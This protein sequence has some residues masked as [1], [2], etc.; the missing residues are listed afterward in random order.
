M[1]YGI[2]VDGEEYN[3][4]R[5]LLNSLIPERDDEVD[6]VAV[7]NIYLDYLEAPGSFV[8]DRSDS[9][10]IFDVGEQRMPLSGF[11]RTAYYWLTGDRHFI[12]V[13]AYDGTPHNRKV[14]NEV[15]KEKVSI[16]P[17]PSKSDEAIRISI[18]TLGDE[19]NKYTI[20]VYQSTGEL[21]LKENI[22]SGESHIKVE[23]HL[24]G[25]FFVRIKDQDKT[26]F[27]DRI[28]RI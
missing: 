22:S 16:Y 27:S 4:A 17:N 14:A 10:M 26:I 7:Q 28:I 20:E 13:P 24:K 9:E 11:A 18:E 19:H 2:M 21:I 5:T 25:L 3:R 1:A 12:T 15:D 6:F 8:L 23:S